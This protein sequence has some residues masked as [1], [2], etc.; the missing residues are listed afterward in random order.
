MPPTDAQIIAAFIAEADEIESRSTPHARGMATARRELA[1]N[2]AFAE[3]ERAVYMRRVGNH[4]ATAFSDAGQKIAA[5]LVKFNTD[6]DGK[7]GR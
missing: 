5:A 2:L 4:V 1:N 3:I 6:Q 7:K